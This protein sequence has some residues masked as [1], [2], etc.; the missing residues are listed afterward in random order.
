MWDALNQLKNQTVS[1][2]VS[3]AGQLGGLAK[4]FAKDV[5]ETIFAHLKLL[6]FSIM[7]VVHWCSS[8]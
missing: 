4:G 3:K 6:M 2:A 7:N 8:R 1:K 5:I